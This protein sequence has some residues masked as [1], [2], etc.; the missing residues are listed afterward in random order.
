MSEESIPEEVRDFILQH[1]ESVATLEALLL[2]KNQPQQEW[3]ASLMAQR[4]YIASPEAERILTT[5]TH[6]GFSAPVPAKA[7]CYIFWPATPEIRD[8]IDRVA[9]VYAKCLIPV[10]NLIHQRGS[11]TSNRSLKLFSDA[12]RLTKDPKEK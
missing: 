1:I 7:G 9:A 11:Q 8:R 2:L 12:F 3:N 4:L 10:T 5:L 6:A